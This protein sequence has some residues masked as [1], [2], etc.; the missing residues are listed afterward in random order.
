MNAGLPRLVGLTPREAE[1]EN[2]ILTGRNRSQISSI[3]GISRHT[4]K[5]H[6]RSILSKRNARDEM[7]LVFNR[8]EVKPRKAMK[9]SA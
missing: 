8:C 9:A 5:F 7:D 3:L 4:V 2:L 1:I 6:V